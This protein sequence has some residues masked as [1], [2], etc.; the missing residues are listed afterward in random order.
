MMDT[1]ITAVTLGVVDVARSVRFYQDMGL[2][3]GFSMEDVAFIEMNGAMLCLYRDLATD[4]RVE[5]ERL[6]LTALAQNVRTKE[7][8]DAVLDQAFDA[9]GRVTRPAHDADWGG[10]SGYFTDPDGHLW[11]IAWN[12]HWPMDDQGRV[13]LGAG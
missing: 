4:A 13:K 2:K 12:P 11:E 5:R 3:V 6:G 10:R 7:E 8:V 1:R 9:G